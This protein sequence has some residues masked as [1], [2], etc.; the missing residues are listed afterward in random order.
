[1]GGVRR[2]EELVAWQE[3]HALA[4]EVYLISGGGEIARS[5]ALR[6]QMRRSALSVVSNIAEG[7]DRYGRRE[8]ANSVRIARGSAAE[9]R[10]QVRL[11]LDLGFLEK[12][13][14]VRLLESCNRVSG[15]LVGLRRS[16]EGPRKSPPP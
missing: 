14:G 15:L 6:E 13:D 16:L 10:A 8:F 3:A 7:Y 4:R 12:R 9:L 11:A 1:M 5:T 2:F